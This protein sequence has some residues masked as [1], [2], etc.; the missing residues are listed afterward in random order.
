MADKRTV[1]AIVRR[2]YVRAVERGED[3]VF[4]AHIVELPNVISEA[5]RRTRRWKTWKMRSRVWYT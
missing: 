1:S 5:T 2:R 4:T 3:G